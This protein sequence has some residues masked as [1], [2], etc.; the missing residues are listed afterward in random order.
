MSHNRQP[1]PQRCRFKKIFLY[2]QVDINKTPAIQ[3]LCHLKLNHP[4]N[5]LIDMD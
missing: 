2:S 4:E 5:P 1:V 3:A